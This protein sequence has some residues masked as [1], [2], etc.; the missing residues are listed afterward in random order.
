MPR[1][2]R[3]VQL[4]SLALVALLMLAACG[5]GA[6]GPENA[7]APPVADTPQA[8]PEKP[9]EP[10]IT[11]DAL[12]VT[13]NNVLREHVFLTTAAT[14]AALAGNTTGF[15]AAEKALKEGNSVEFADLIG[16]MYDRDT[17]EAFITLW[18]SHVDMFTAYTNGLVKNDTAAQ[19]KANADL[20]QYST[21]F[22]AA[23]EKITSLPATT[24]QPLIV[25][26]IGTLKSVIDKQKAGDIAGAYTDLRNAMRHMDTIAKPLAAQI[27][28]QK[29]FAGTAESKAADLQTSLNGLLQEHV[30]LTGAATGAALAGNTTSFE[31]S[32]KAEKEGNSVDLANRLSEIYGRDT[33]DTFLGLWNSKIDL[34]M[35]YTNGLVKN[36]K[37]AQD[38]AVTDLTNYV[39]SLAS[40]FEKITEGGLPAGASS[41]LIQQHVTTLKTVVDMQKI[42]NMDAAYTDLREAAHHMRMIADPLAQTIVKQKNIS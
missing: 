18:N 4:V 41:S 10:A 17:R 9:A 2:L 35:A 5:G 29:S 24:S 28:K 8:E 26:H 7:S 15:E 25:E 33:G 40:V 37:P 27:A 42:G 6:T 31:A 14:G 19:D 12:R 30:F 3:G 21:D 13:L 22:A 36:D 11:A 20:M 38:K 34:F 1:L 16:K 32:L 23:L 39:G